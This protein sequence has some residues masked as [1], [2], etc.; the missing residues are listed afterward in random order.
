MSI[1]PSNDQEKRMSDKPSISRRD[2]LGIATWAIGGLISLGMGIPAIAYIIGPALKRVESQE[3]IRLGAASKV[4]IGVPTLFKTKIERQTGWITSETELSIY[5]ITE[6]G[7]DFAAMSNV[8]T[9]LGC[10]VRW[11]ADQ[12][13]FFCPCHN[14]VFDKDGNVVA[15]PPPRPLDRYEINVEDDQLYVL[16]G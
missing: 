6:N 1:S 16:G 3:W 12:E 2:F 13:Q 8:C 7:R 10:R 15:G 4:E 5:V 11:N 9:H 14:A